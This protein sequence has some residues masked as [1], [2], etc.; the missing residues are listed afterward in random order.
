MIY[1][2]IYIY[3][4]IYG[5]VCFNIV[6]TGAWSQYL[7]APCAYWFRIEKDSFLVRV[8]FRWYAHVKL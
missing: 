6:T 7:S 5:S 8:G 1:I 3:M 4:Y 2:Y